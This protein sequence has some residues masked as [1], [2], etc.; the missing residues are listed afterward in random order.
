M[1]ILPLKGLV[2]CS[3]TRRTR[4]VHVT[5]E[6]RK[7]EVLAA[8][9]KAGKKRLVGWGPRILLGRTA[10]RGKDGSK[11]TQKGLAKLVGLSHQQ[12]GRYESETDEPGYDTW[13]KLSMALQIAPGP[14]VFGDQCNR[15]Q[16]PPTQPLT[17]R[18]P[19]LDE[20]P[21]AAKRRA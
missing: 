7:G 8:K 11:V 3:H 21:K 13:L 4:T 14:L 19:E 12:I 2:N 5:L 6:S 18:P 1:S 17:Q 15:I 20:A 9:K 10:M 16:L